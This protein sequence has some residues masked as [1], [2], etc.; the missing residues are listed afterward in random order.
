MISSLF[1]SNANNTFPTVLAHGLGDSC[2][3][4]GMKEI[5][6]DVGTHIGTYSVCVPTGDTWLSD[7]INGFAKK[8]AADPK[9][10]NGFNAIGFSQGNSLIRGYIHKYN[11]PPVLNVLHVHG[12]VSGVSG[13]PQCFQ[14]EK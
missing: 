9:L 10:A 2:F 3:N 1:D 14:Q 4:G 6:K 7:T 8:I 13:F 12:T 11:D 5:T